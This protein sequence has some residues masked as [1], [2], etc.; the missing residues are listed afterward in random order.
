[1][2]IQNYLI[3]ENNVV[4]NN[5][6]WDGNTADWTPP[7]DSIVLVQATTPAM[8]WELNTATPPVYVLTEVIGAG[9]IGFTWNG[10]V[11]TTNQPQPTPPKPAT[12]QPATNGTTTI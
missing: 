7:T 5:V 11:L 3:I 10:S 1:M 4:T 6:V 12:N 9:D 8:V 2:T